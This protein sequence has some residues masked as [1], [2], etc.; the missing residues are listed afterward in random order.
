MYL[1]ACTILSAAII[2][3][4]TALFI[5]NSDKLQPNQGTNLFRHRAR[6]PYRPTKD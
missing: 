4:I 1:D 2:L 6:R 3:V 5:I